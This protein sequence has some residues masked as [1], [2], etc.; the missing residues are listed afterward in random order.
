MSTE[1]FQI[2][3]N[4]TLQTQLWRVC[5][6]PASKLICERNKKLTVNFKMNEKKVNRQE[7]LHEKF[8]SHLHTRGA[9]AAA[10][11]DLAAKFKKKKSCLQKKT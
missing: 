2:L 6:A 1:N 7:I 11:A 8:A 3:Q 10:A 5:Q 9:A 4:F